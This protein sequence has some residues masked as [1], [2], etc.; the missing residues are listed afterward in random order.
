MENLKSGFKT[1]IITLAITFSLTGC[2]QIINVLDFIGVIPPWEHKLEFQLGKQAIE[3][4]YTFADYCEEKYDSIFLVYP[5]FN[6]ERTDYTT[7]KMSN[8]LRGICNANI[9]FD[10]FSTILFIK[11]GKV[12]AYSEIQCVDADFDSREV[13]KHYTFPI[14]QKFIMDKERSIH[15]YKE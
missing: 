15:L 1:I 5:Y 12:E 8:S 2:T 7:L 6:T 14:D 13:E 11:N 9:N 3:E 4:P 10:H